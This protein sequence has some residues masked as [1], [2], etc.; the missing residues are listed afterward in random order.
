ML[1][2]GFVDRPEHAD[3]RG[4]AAEATVGNRAAPGRSVE[5]DDEP[6]VGGFG[7]DRVVECHGHR[8]RV[9][10]VEAGEAG[11][12][13][14]LL[15]V[16][17]DVDGEPAQRADGRQR[18]LFR[19]GHHGERARDVPTDHRLRSGG[20][21][22]RCRRF[23]VGPHVVLA[24]RVDVADAIRRAGH[25]VGVAEL[26]EQ[27]RVAF[28]RRR[29]VGER[30]E[31]DEVVLAG[32]VRRDLEEHTDGVDGRGHTGGFW[33]GRSTHAVLA[34]HELCGV[35]RAGE[36]PI[37]TC[38][39]RDVGAAGEIERDDRV[40]NREVERHVAGHHGDGAH[41]DRRVTHGEHQ[42]DRVVGCGV[43]VDH[44]A[45]SVHLRSLPASP[46]PRPSPRPT[47]AQACAQPTP[48]LKF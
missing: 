5:A 18:S 4:G 26:R 39:Q 31:R 34:V 46:S 35:E 24:E 2:R 36:R 41:V 44:D 6:F 47:H 3:V 8:D 11:V 45:A 37:T 10:E 38:V 9:G 20:C 21:E 33:Q 7:D 28:E 23:R 13:A 14:V 12:E 32:F 16:A 19:V 48:T 15:D 40:A 1:E 30:A 42:G 29:D 25:Q 27:F 17:V 43:G 22:H